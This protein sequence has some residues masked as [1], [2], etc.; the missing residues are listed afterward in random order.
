MQNMKLTY[1]HY[2]EL[3]DDAETQLEMYHIMLARLKNSL[4]FDCCL[5]KTWFC[6]FV[7]PALRASNI[8]AIT[9]LDWFMSSIIESY[10]NNKKNI[11]DSPYIQAILEIFMETL[12]DW[13][14]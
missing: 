13:N 3:I 9:I 7:V 1:I 5:W 11:F 2:F 6:S 8:Y 14:V 10:W 12:F 4:D